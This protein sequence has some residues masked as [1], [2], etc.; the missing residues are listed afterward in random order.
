LRTRWELQASQNPKFVYS[1]ALA[2]LLRLLGTAFPIVPLKGPLELQSRRTIFWFF[3]TSRPIISKV[4][5][6]NFENVVEFPSPLNSVNVYKIRESMASEIQENSSLTALLW[7]RQWIDYLEKHR[8]LTQ[9]EFR[10]LLDHLE[11]QGR[12]QWPDLAP[13]RKGKPKRAVA[14]VA[15]EILETIE[16]GDTEAFS[17]LFKL[18][19][20]FNE[21]H[22]MK[23]VLKR[24]FGI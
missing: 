17:R 3:K 19:T 16:A 11:D 2:I 6:D 4:E 24:R 7:M 12:H 8:R 5:T 14:I 13:G 21:Q 22:D 20:N 15:T 9:H 1:L 18:I 23:E 10:C